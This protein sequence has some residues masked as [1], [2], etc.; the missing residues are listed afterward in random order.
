[1]LTG[2]GTPAGFTADETAED[3][4]G[5]KVEENKGAVSIF[6]AVVAAEARTSLMRRMVILF[7]EEEGMEE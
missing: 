1:M 7:R 5:E 2:A 4:D 3:G 6:R